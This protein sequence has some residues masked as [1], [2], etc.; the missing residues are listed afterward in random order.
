[1]IRTNRFTFDRGRFTYTQENAQD[2]YQSADVHGRRRH[3][4]PQ[5]R[6]HRALRDSTSKA[7]RSFERD[8]ALGCTDALII[9]PWTRSKDSDGCFPARSHLGKRLPGAT[10]RAPVARRFLD[11]APKH[12]LTD[13]PTK[14]FSTPSSSARRYTRA[15]WRR[16]RLSAEPLPV[17]REFTTSDGIS[18][19]RWTVSGETGCGTAE[20]GSPPGRVAYTRFAGAQAP[21]STDPR[22]AAVPL[23]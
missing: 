11:V 1:M 5:P 9:S 20:R 21:G 6:Q 7:I 18:R 23:R 14:K 16:R 22:R 3:G 8:D 15:R 13:R 19:P 17:M 12:R 4:R 10:S 2:S